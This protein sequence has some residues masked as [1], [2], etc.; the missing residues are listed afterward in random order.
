MHLSVVHRALQGEKSEKAP[1]VGTACVCRHPTCC[2]KRLIAA[3]RQRSAAM[4][5]CGTWDERRSRFYDRS[6]PRYLVTMRCVRLMAE[7]NGVKLPGWTARSISVELTVQA[8]QLSE[9]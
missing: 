7:T 5:T 1:E 2:M 3:G 9:C 8:S 6:A 4:F